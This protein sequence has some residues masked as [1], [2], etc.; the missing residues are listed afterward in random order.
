MVSAAHARSPPALQLCEVGGRLVI[1]IAPGVI[2]RKECGYGS[3]MV[4]KL[5]CSFKTLVYAL[6]LTILPDIRSLQSPIYS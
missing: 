4:D 3:S 2:E 6:N 5:Q 1:S